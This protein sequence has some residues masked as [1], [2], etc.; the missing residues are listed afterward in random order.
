MKGWLKALLFF[1]AWLLAQIIFTSPLM[2]AL[3]IDGKS[4]NSVDAPN[5]AL[6][7]LI[8]A[9]LQLVGTGI[10][11]YLFL[12]H[13]DKAPFKVLGLSWKGNGQNLAWGL[14]LG[15]GLI[16]VGTLAL[17]AAG[18]VTLNFSQFSLL[19]I[20]ISII[21]FAIVAVNEEV[22]A[23]GYLLR[24]LMESANKYWALIISALIFAFLHGMN[25][26]ISWVAL[27]NLFLAGVLLGIYYI[28]YKNLWF[29]IGIHFT[30]N[31]FQGPIWGS[32]V[33]GTTTESLFSQ[34]LSGNDLITGGAFGFEGS[35][36][37]SVLTILSIV[38]VEVWARRNKPS[39][40]SLPL[41]DIEQPELA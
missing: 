27:L 31:F 35:L 10:A 5:S 13:I 29:S 6:I 11:V 25:P 15:A 8:A 2:L 33:S 14:L 19:S 16:S 17:M 30:W 22:M 18:M 9:T 24:V 1:F 38:A 21:L 3:G 32:N 23:R 20:F 34:Q 26:N 28:H 4:I 12:K 39:C 36:M 37:C 7:L 41:E 40:E